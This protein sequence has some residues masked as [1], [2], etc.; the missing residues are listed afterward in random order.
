M[1]HSSLSLLV[2]IAGALFLASTS[3]QQDQ[4]DQVSKKTVLNQSS[5]PLSQPQV[6]DTWPEFSPDGTSQNETQS[7]G[8]GGKNR[9]IGGATTT[10]SPSTRRYCPVY[11][12]TSVYSSY[13]C[14]RW[15]GYYGYPYYYW[16]PYRYL[17]RLIY[18]TQDTYNVIIGVTA[19]ATRIMDC[20]LG[21][22][23]VASW[24]WIWNF[25]FIFYFTLAQ[26]PVLFEIHSSRK[27]C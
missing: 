4:Q 16:Y 8:V 9:R 17:A 3:L 18:H 25:Q 15:C 6:P 21:L 7:T 5:N 2:L 27:W 26:A 19:V 13:T 14:A 22:W 1:Q 23:T 11:F 20:G 10:V 24:I 12:S